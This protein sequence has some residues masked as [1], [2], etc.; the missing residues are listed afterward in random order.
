MKTYYFQ[1]GLENMTEL[2]YLQG[3]YSLAT[4]K[5]LEVEILP[6]ASELLFLFVI[7]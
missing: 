5:L 2:L 1:E 6:K 7:C 3:F 4:K